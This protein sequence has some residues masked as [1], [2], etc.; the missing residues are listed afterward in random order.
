MVNRKLL[1]QRYLKNTMTWLRQKFIPR[2]LS[3]GQE[4]VLLERLCLYS[5]LQ[6]L[7]F[8]HLTALPSKVCSYLERGGYH[9]FIPACRKRKERGRAHARHLKAKNW[10]C[11]RHFL[12]TSHWLK[13]IKHT[14]MQESLENS[15]QLDGHLPSSNSGGAQGSASSSERRELWYE[16]E[17]IGHLCLT[18]TLLFPFAWS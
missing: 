13:L 12:F 11:S 9:I 3:Q 5:V 14:W 1:Q 15:F 6:K 4:S 17:E 18:E 8:L 7:S 16:R 2:K 10:N